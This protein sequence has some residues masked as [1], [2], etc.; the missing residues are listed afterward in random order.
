M[1][2]AAIALGAV[3][4]HAVEAAPADRQS[5]AVYEFQGMAEVGAASLT[6]TGSGV[7]MTIDTTI[8]GELEDF[9]TPLGVDWGPAGCIGGCGEDDVLDAIFGGNRAKVGVHYG[10]G[11][12]AGGDGFAAAAHLQ[13]GDMSG[14]VLGMGLMDAMSAEIHLVVRSHG[15]AASLTGSQLAAALHSLNG[16]CAAADMGPNVC[17]DSQFAVFTARNEHVKAVAAGEDC[18][19]DPLARGSPGPRLLP[20]TGC[21]SMPS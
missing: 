20:P 14:A 19:P 4:T 1:I 7:T 15:P 16:G 5:S 12:V 13:E 21:T 11:H 10:A 6:R 3:G 18:H 2:A 8:S 17:G 9:G